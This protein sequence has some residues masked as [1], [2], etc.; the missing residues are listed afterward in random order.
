M[1]LYFCSVFFPSYSLSPHSVNC[2]TTHQKEPILLIWYTY[3]Y[4]IICIYRILF[5]HFFVSWLSTCQYFKGNTTNQSAEMQIIFKGWWIVY[6]KKMCP[7]LFNHCQ[8]LGIH[9]TVIYNNILL[10]CGVGEDSWESPGLQG[11]PTS[12]P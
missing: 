2:P 8:F 7:L 9:T 12:P 10:N 4:I 5:T 1:E 3:A 6:R 11:D